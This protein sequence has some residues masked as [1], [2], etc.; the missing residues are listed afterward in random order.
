M[1]VNRRFTISNYLPERNLGK[2]NID[3]IDGPK[4]SQ[5]I[6][7]SQAGLQKRLDNPKVQEFFKNKSVSML[8]LDKISRLIGKHHPDSM[9]AGKFT[10]G[11][12]FFPSFE[13]IRHLSN[14]KNHPNL[15]KN[16]IQNLEKWIEDEKNCVPFSLILDAWSSANQELTNFVTTEGYAPNVNNLKSLVKPPPE[17][18]EIFSNALAAEI[19][20][21]VEGD[22]IKLPAGSLLHVTRLEITKNND[23]SFDII[24]FNTGDGALRFNTELVT[25]SKYVSIPAKNLEDPEFWNEFVEVKMQLQMSKL[26][27]LLQ[28]LNPDTPPENIDRILKKQLQESNS[29]SFQSVEAEFKYSFIS[30]FSNP[31]E[32][33][34]AYKQITSL[35]LTEVV[36]HESS[37]INESLERM[38]LFKGKTRQ[39]YLDWMSIQN[40]AV[41][42]TA[43]KT[44]YMDALSYLGY[45]LG[46]DKL[47][48]ENL[49]SLQTLSIL[50][51]NLNKCLNSVT[52]DK[53]IQVRD[54]FG[55][56]LTFNHFN[57]VG[58]K[59]LI[60]LEST[61][62]VF[63]DIIDFSG[64]KGYTLLKLKQLSA[65]ALPASQNAKVQ[66][67]INFPVL[68]PKELSKLLTEYLIRQD[69]TRTEQT[70]QTLQN[71]NIINEN[72]VYDA[73]VIIN[74]IK[75]CTHPNLDIV[76][77][78]VIQMPK[79]ERFSTFKTILS[80][81]AEHGTAKD[82]NKV[83]DY[84]GNLT[85]ESEKAELLYIL[86]NRLSIHNKFK[87]AINIASRISQET[88]KSEA[89][90]D[91]CRAQIN[92]GNIDDA[93][94]STHSISDEEALESSHIDICHALV[95]D[96][97]IEEAVKI[98]N[99]IPE[100]KRSSSSRSISVA[101]AKSG[102]IDKALEIA[103]SII[104]EQQK[105]MAFQSIA[106]AYVKIGKIQEALNLIGTL[107]TTPNS[108]MQFIKDKSFGS[109]A[110]EMAKRGNTQDAV[111]LTKTIIDERALRIAHEEIIQM[112]VGKGD[113]EVAVQYIHT[114]QKEFSND[115]WISII[116][117]ECDKG[118]QQISLLFAQND[119][120]E[121]GKA[122]ALTIQDEKI[123][124][125]TLLDIS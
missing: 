7:K 10:F 111:I 30:S 5:L 106:E 113:A 27:D 123:R 55:S 95:K 88:K 60:W 116:Q 32:G 11:P 8:F 49:S 3:G 110:L 114:I 84:L 109:I 13:L 51:K 78:I 101:I 63:Q 100:S 112:L 12:S 19:K 16:T 21:M 42:F 1:E 62:E 83:I 121:E 93:L 80:K 90:L 22:R 107:K 125:K 72:F 86:C 48:I 124:E 23:G 96:G 79:E 2:N 33:W 17:E 73:D 40:D 24:H 76:L 44:A 4:F 34:Q 50:D 9:E 37:T 47:E 38:L 35:M 71:A 89:F 28:K 104:S 69:S 39:R 68:N 108:L 67:S 64:L 70:L 65:I 97:R 119:R 43:A 61:R 105:A 20:S 94:V 29:C 103:G 122:L 36:E 82:L 59:Q 15:S 98:S 57:H 46:A 45:D 102:K 92:R 120:V 41:K 31:D 58:F 66:S 118:L 77:D 75:E 18:V 26:N 6:S 115:K 25:A 14:L 56:D 87:E 53:L 99:K 81:I 85:D 74:H 54:K 117:S 91:I 52:F